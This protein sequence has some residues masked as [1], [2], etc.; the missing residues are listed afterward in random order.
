MSV[1]HSITYT[2]ATGGESVTATQSKSAGQSIIL[3]ESLSS[4]TDQLVALTLDISQLKSIYLV[5]TTAATIETNSSSA[6]DDTIT[7]AAGVPLV[8]Q[9]S[10][11]HA[12][13]F[14]A[15]V[16]AIYVTNAAATVLTGY[17]LVDPTV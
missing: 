7:L 13:P 11:Y 6:A 8:W 10:T 1:Q 3:S 16:T 5:S 2:L 15:D 4:G 14:S 17:F 9:E 12:N